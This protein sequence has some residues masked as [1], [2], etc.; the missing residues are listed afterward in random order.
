MNARNRWERCADCGR[1]S[2]ASRGDA[3]R[4]RRLQ[5][6]QFGTNLSELEIFRCR[7][8]DSGAFHLGW[9]SPDPN[10][11]AQQVAS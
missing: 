5:V 1:R 11:N 4:V 6:K 7:E 3:R 2:Y 9:G 8:G 10:P